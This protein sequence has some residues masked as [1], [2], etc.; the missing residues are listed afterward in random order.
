M[1]Y[2]CRRSSLSANAPPLGVPIDAVLFCEG[3][4]TV[5]CS[6]IYFIVNKLNDRVQLQR[7][8]RCPTVS[9]AVVYTAIFKGGF[10]ETSGRFSR[11]G[12]VS[13]I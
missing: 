1:I 9:N 2:C 11:I 12:P 8:F 6:T 4:M 5:Q 7:G 10:D 3:V 13:A